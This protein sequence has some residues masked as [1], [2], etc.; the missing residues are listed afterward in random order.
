MSRIPK[1]AL[2]IGV[3]FLGAF[4]APGYALAGDEKLSDLSL[5]DLLTQDVTSVAKKPQHVDEAAAAIFV[6]TQDDIRRSG[7]KTLPDLFRMVPGMEVATLPSGGAAVSARG[8]NGVFS[9][10]LLVLVDGREVYQSALSGVF[11]DQQLVPLQDIQRIEVVRGP[12]ATLWGANAVNGVINIVTRHPADALGVGVSASADSTNGGQV[13]ARLGTRLGDAGALRLYATSS[14]ERDLATLE[15]Q[16]FS[17]VHKA[18]QTGFRYDQDLSASQALTVQGDLQVGHSSMP[19]T[20]SPNPGF[21]AF[22]Y[23]GDFSGANLLSRWVD[24][25]GPN[26]GV[27]VEAY[28]DYWKRRELGIVAQADTYNL[29]LSGHVRLGD[30]NEVVAG[31]AYRRTD[32]KEQTAGTIEFAPASRGLDWY[33]AYVQDDVTLVPERLNLSAGVKIENNAYANFEVEPSLRLIWRSPAGWAVWA[34]A[35]RAARTPS[36]FETALQFNF[37]QEPFVSSPDLKPETL[38][39]YEVG[40]RAKLNERLSIDLTAYRNQYEHLIVWT[41]N[42]ATTPPYFNLNFDNGGA[43]T[44]QGIE[45]AIEARPL[46][47]WTLKLAA[48]DMHLQVARGGL[49]V[50]YAV[51]NAGNSP[52]G[53]VSI[54]SIYDLSD[55]IDLDIWYRH[56]DALSSG[57]VKPY[58]DLSTR[59][60]WRPTPTYEFYIRGANLLAARRIEMI[61]TGLPSPAAIVQRRVEVGLSARY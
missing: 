1:L 59:I 46:A 42:P 23:G 43:A 56:V 40:W 45:A 15:N 29:D 50:G 6:I 22:S 16:T 5:E 12:G 14:S 20:P 2:M 60:A 8:F 61:N 57:P 35:S 30:R 3:A 27:A 9:N 10:K 52:H 48:S 19:S 49:P 17:D 25:L 37:A 51:F 24:T 11:W 31:A 4:A 36:R 13:F 38:T 44:G 21:P 26:A 55:K 32:D 47:R 34:A 18:T 39:A 58:S 28:A 41:M 53:Q 33:S 54:R 7:A